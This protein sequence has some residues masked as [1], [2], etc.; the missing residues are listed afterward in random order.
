MD[1]LLNACNGT[2]LA[3]S[4]NGSVF[5][6]KIFAIRRLTSHPFA[7][8]Y[9]YHTPTYRAAGAGVVGED[10]AR[11]PGSQPLWTETIS[12]NLPPPTTTLTMVRMRPRVRMDLGFLGPILPLTCFYY[13]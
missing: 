9:E 10:M 3:I 7:P 2:S 13:I 12:I 11:T 4:S 1:P 8:P 6:C 5:H